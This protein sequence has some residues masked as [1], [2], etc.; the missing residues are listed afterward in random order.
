MCPDFSSRS[1]RAELMDDPSINAAELEQ[2]VDHLARVNTVLG[3]H[4]PTVKGIEALAG[5]REELS[6]LDIG[7]GSGDVP[8]RLVKWAQ[9]R[10]TKLRVTGIDLSPTI[11]AHARRC[12]EGF[13]NIEI[14]QYDLFNMPD[15]KTY[16]IVHAALVLHHLPGKAAA[17]GLKKMYELSRLGV[18]INDLHRHR[19]AYLG[20]RLILPLLSKNRLIRHD[21]ALSVMRSFTREELYALARR[22]GL[23]RPSIRWRALFRWQMVVRKGQA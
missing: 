4:R 15:D 6:V 9:S 22:A 21:G 19:L 5:D 16:D 11:A 2:T 17:K 23:P 7:T 1:E 3:G 10:G 13:E 12:C 20:S 14:E 8:K 18:V